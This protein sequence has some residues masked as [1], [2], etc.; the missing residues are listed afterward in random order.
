MRHLV[1]LLPILTAKYMS[2]GNGHDKAC[3]KLS[4][5]LATSY[6]AMEINSAGE[7]P[8]WGQ[9]V[10][11]QYMALEREALRHKADI[12]EW[13]IAPKLHHTCT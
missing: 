7:M 3:H 10:A 8:K 4:R 9:K 11:R 13:R 6:A 2:G 5:F 12:L 1:P